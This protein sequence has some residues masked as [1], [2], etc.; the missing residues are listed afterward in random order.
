MPGKNVCSRIADPAA[1][2]RCENYQG[3]FAQEA[4]PAA[5]PVAAPR[6]GS[7]R[8]GRPAG[9]RGRLASRMPRRNS[10][11]RNRGGGFG[12]RGGY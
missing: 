9:A 7:D 5:R 2:R 1:R 6:V 11:S 3:E 8:F 10:L 4:G 12:G